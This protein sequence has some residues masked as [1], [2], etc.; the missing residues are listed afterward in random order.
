MVALYS[1]ENLTRDAAWE[2]KCVDNFSA[3][4]PSPRWELTIDIGLGSQAASSNPVVHPSIIP[5]SP[6]TAEKSLLKQLHPSREVSVDLSLNDKK[7]I[8]KLEPS[9]EQSLALLIGKYMPL[10]RDGYTTDSLAGSLVSLHLYL[11]RHSSDRASTRSKIV[12]IILSKY[13]TYLRDT[14]MK[15]HDLIVSIASDWK[16]ML[17]SV[18]AGFSNPLPIEETCRSSF[19]GST[20]STAASSFLSD[21]AQ[22]SA[23]QFGL[24]DNHVRE[25]V[26]S[27]AD[28][29]N[30]CISSS[31]TDT[32]NSSNV[33][34]IVSDQGPIKQDTD[35][36]GERS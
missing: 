19:L 1:A 34:R 9:P 25:L 36:D 18:N 15:E 12:E 32:V 30:T 21:S 17:S 14:N 8:V 5:L 27:G 26:T 24:E 31:L 10:E 29:A 33:R 2:K 13:Q 23:S 6:T 35:N 22:F 16:R 4:K 11:L 20:V 7:P 3:L 28:T